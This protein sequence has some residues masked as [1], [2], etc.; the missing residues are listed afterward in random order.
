MSY[1]RQNGY[2][3]V[4]LMIVVAILSVLAGI[5]IPIYRNY[6]VEARLQAARQN[7]E[8]LRLA[9]EDY[10]LDNHTY[11]AGSWVPGGDTSLESGDL[12][13]RPDGDGNKYSYVVTALA[14]G[15]IATG[16][17]LTVSDVNYT[18]A[19]VTCVRNQT[20]GSYVCN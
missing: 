2:N 19:H 1:K 15:S 5:A 3:L 10:F 18:S 11:I 9:L 7:A 16:Y 13:W 12:G 14:G 20:A 6:T 4:E 17:S 8:P